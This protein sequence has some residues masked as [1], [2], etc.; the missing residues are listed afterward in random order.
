MYTIGYK[1]EDVSLY[2]NFSYLNNS[3]SQQSLHLIALCAKKKINF[4]VVITAN[5]QT[6]SSGI[7]G[8]SGTQMV[9]QLPTVYAH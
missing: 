4:K 5:T 2:C 3:C 8:L 9:G 1:T 6:Q 7:A